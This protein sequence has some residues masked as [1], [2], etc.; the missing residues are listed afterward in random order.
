MTRVA[1]VAGM[2][3][4]FVKAGKAFKDL[5]PLRLARES[6]RGLLDTHQVP[7][8]SIESLAY[9]VVVPEPGRPNLA[10][11]IVFE[12]K[13]PGGIEA[14]TMSS[15]CITGLRTIASIAEAI[16]AGRMECGIAG[17]VDSLSHADP[18]TFIEPSTG[19]S[20][21]EHTE[22]TRKKWGIRRE[23]QDEIALASHRNAVAARDRLSSEIHP[24]LGVEQDSGPRPETSLEALSALKPVF[25]PEGTLTA[26]NSS[27]VTDGASAVLLMSEDRARREG[28]KPL[29][30]IRAV[31][32]AAHD[33]SEGLLMAPAIAVPR[34]LATSGL[35]LSDMDLI[36]IHEAFAAQVLANVAAWEQGWKGEPTSPVDW[37]RVNVNGSSLAIGHPWAA[38][39]GRIVTTLANEL[40]RRDGT[41]G[42]VSICAAGAMAGAL[43]LERA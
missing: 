5:G 27:P 13:L 19:L 41:F 31:A 6:V 37:G 7:A 10:R 36:E 4:P 1:I 8:E 40:A 25:D 14:Q 11:E 29:A 43:I 24:V 15:Y 42:L 23:R 26:G 16:Q 28:R 30:L 17:G 3:T 21:G 22:L 35:K 38:T 9:G 18:A 34:V 33:P 20:M 12:E 32:F 2:R 39:G